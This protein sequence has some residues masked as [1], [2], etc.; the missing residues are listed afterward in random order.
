M[1]CHHY[2]NQTENHNKFWDITLLDNNDVIIEWGKISNP[3]QS[4]VYRAAGDDFFIKKTEEKTKKGYIL[5]IKEEVYGLGNNV[6]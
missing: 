6:F 3:P 1:K 2:I 4:K 5:D